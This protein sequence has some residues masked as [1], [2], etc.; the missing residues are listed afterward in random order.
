MHT[1]GFGPGTGRTKITDAANEFSDL[2]VNYSDFRWNVTAGGIE[3]EPDFALCITG[4][5]DIEPTA[6]GFIF[7]WTPRQQQSAPAG[8]CQAPSETAPTALIERRQNRSIRNRPA[9]VRPATS[10]IQTPRPSQPSMK[11]KT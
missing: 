6:D 11:P 4:I 10:P 8:T 1:D 9:Q 5:F 2:P 7:T 3:P